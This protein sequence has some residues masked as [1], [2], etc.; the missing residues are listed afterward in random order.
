MK[1]LLSSIAVF[2]MSIGLANAADLPSKKAQP[3]G[4]EFVKICNAYGAG[5]FTIPGTDTC[6]RVG[7]MLRYDQLY[8]PAQ[9]Q[10]KITA[11]AKAVSSAAAGQNTLGNE[12]R[13]RIDLDS[14]TPTEYGT[15]RT[16]MQ[17]RLGRQGGSMAEVSQPTGASQSAS[18]TSPVLETAYI[19]F[20][21]FTAGAARDN[22]AFMPSRIYG[23]QHWASF[24]INPKQ[25]SYTALFGN[26]LS[27][28]VAIQDPADT[29]IAPVDAINAST[30]YYQRSTP[31]S[32]QLNGNVRWDQSWGGLQVM[33]AT[34][35][36]NGVDATGLVYDQ[37][38]QV[39]AAGAGLKINLPMIAQGDAIWITGA[40]AD[41][42]TEYTTAYGSNKI[43]NWRRDVGGFQTN[44]P[45]VIYYSTGIESVKS[46]SVGALAEHWWTPNWRS[47]IFGSYGQVTAPDTAKAKVW[48]GKGGFGDAT[49]WSVGKNI[50]WIPVKDFELGVEGTYSNMKQD[51][52]Y[53]LASSTN[54]VK[55]ESE[56]NW[57][58]KLRAER[59]F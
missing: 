30:A 2:A 41:G 5:F 53:T 45:S 25:L 15:I 50:A 48:D 55:S 20:A 12:L 27:A 49:V 51:V 32:V 34:R 10:Y 17:V 31:G 40:Y 56:N 57:T 1:N 58:M 43:S 19:Q 24:I 59:R 54:V 47:N 37:T 9:D 22:F 4:A 13:A 38:K 29:G 14:R 33:G 16:F 6:L 18:T 42:M 36:A 11:G 28:T 52:R 23:S 3:A 35:Q 46:W 44:H 8:A 21:G 7:G 39:W 26:G